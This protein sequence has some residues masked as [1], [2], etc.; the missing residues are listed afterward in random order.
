VLNLAS[1]GQHRIGAHAVANAE[2]RSWTDA[3]QSTSFSDAH[4][5]IQSLPDLPAAAFRD[6]G[7]PE[8]DT[9]RTSTLLT[10]DDALALAEPEIVGPSYSRHSRDSLAGVA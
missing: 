3:G 1:I 6:R 2:N 8:P 4:A 5:R 9:S 7:A 10:L